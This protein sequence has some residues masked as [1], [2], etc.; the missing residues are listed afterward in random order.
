[1]DVRKLTGSIGAEILGVDLSK[2]LSNDTIK[3]IRETLLNNLV[4]FFETRR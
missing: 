4:I 1:M 2:D 3:D